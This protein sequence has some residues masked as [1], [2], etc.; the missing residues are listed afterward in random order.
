MLEIAASEAAEAPL[1]LGPAGFVFVPSTVQTL[2][3][4][5]AADCEATTAADLL[6]TELLQTRTSEGLVA[7]L[8]VNVLW[9]YRPEAL[10]ALYLALPPKGAL[11]VFHVDEPTLGRISAVLPARQL[12]AREAASHI[13]AVACR[14]RAHT[15]FSRKAAIALAIQADLRL[16]MR[17]LGIEV[18]S[19][20]L[21][22]PHLPP[23]YEA[24][25]MRSATTRLS[26]VLAARYKEAQRVTFATRALVASFSARA[27]VIRAR[28][29]AQARAQRAQQNA[30]VIAV[31]TAAEVRAYAN[32]TEATRVAPVE[33]MQYTWWDQA[34]RLVATGGQLRAPLRTASLARSGELFPQ[35]RVGWTR[36]GG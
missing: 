15:F 5:E 18:L 13:L 27:T 30:A 34:M 14:Y 1:A 9:R 2:Q 24:A 29:A 12:I 32:V 10:R 21:M 4:S 28:G 3:F 35:L 31:T 22:R 16:E 8:H 36:R 33:L 7:R 26:I 19:V 23:T 11:E 25:L 17:E 6:C 20:Q